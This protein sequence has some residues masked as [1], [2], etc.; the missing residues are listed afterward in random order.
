MR[1]RLNSNPMKTAIAIHQGT[2]TITNSLW[3]ANAVAGGVLALLG[4]LLC[5]ESFGYQLGVMVLGSPVMMFPLGFAGMTFGA[6]SVIVSIWH[7]R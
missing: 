2:S 3:T 1:N 6:A 4:G 5:C 7:I